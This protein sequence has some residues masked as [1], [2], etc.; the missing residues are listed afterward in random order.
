ME[1][2]QQPPQQYYQQ[3]PKIKKPWY[4]IWWMWVIVIVSF[5]ILR[6]P[7][8]ALL[9]VINDAG[10]TIVTNMDN[11]LI[12]NSNKPT[13]TKTPFITVDYATLYNEYKAN[14]VAAD[15]KYKGKWLQLTGQI[16]DIG[17]DLSDDAYITFSISFLS[18]IK[19]I[20]K[21]DQELKVANM[22]K[23]QTITIIG[24]C[25]GYGLS[26]VRL[27]DSVIQ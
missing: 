7:I 2:P 14:E 27:T 22:Q 9:E 11:V 13:P 24:R 16:N 21:D 12:N 23:G 18:D 10:Q 4:D 17:K 1:V 26:E 5:L 3:P 6:M 8:V 20:V 19:I 25:I 15:L